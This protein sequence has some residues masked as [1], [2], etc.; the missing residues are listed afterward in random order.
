M[1][2]C[3]E[4]SMAPDGIVSS[5]LKAQLIV[6]IGRESSTVVTSL[7]SLRI[8]LHLRMDLRVVLDRV[9]NSML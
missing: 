2:L 1:N 9:A 8:P 6:T 4:L 3:M 7:Y 5:P